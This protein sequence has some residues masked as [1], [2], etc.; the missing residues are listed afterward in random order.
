MNSY[1]TGI[2]AD[3]TSIISSP[4]STNLSVALHRL[5]PVAL[6][7]LLLSACASPEGPGGLTTVNPAPAQ[8]TTAVQTA[9]LPG[10][11]TSQPLTASA[12]PGNSGAPQA[13]LPEQSI[14]T[15]VQPDT[16]EA[17][18][19]TL[20]SPDV[21]L[22]DFSRI[23][24][25]QTSGA[26]P[27]TGERGNAFG[28]RPVSDDTLQAALQ[29]G[30]QQGPEAVTTAPAEPQWP[31]VALAPV[32]TAP[33]PQ[34]TQLFDAIDDAAYRQGMQLVFHGDETANYI[35]RSQVSA[36]PADRVTSFIYVFDI[37]D[38]RGV[39]RHRVSGARSI[40]RS[41][42]N[43]WAVVDPTTTQLVA[44]EVAGRLLAWFRANP[45]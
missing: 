14:A 13:L 21:T 25:R 5:I 2:D 3:R 32:T 45:G 28:N 15:S 23:D 20:A 18:Q 36:I 1:Q 39:L 10:T 40:P 6:T 35:V 31:R 43:G 44:D 17:Q 34:A 7:F 19:Q 4:L 11:V 41:D 27:F 33:E 38:T 24:P 16:L 37:F 30:L 9:P 26:D 42:P 12:T 8:P 22:Q 29:D